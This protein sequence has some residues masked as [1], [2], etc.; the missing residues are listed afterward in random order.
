MKQVREAWGDL[1]GGFLLCFTV[2]HSWFLTGSLSLE[3]LPFSLMVLLRFN[4]LF[5]CPVSIL[6]RECTSF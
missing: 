4:Q 2:F 6:R 1:F 5:Y 3:S